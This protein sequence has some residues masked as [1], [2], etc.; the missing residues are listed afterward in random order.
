M[1]FRL[2]T[3]GAALLAVSSPLAH[4]Q[5]RG[6]AT[7]GLTLTTTSF[8]DGGEIP[9]RFTQGVEKPVSPTLAWTNVPA[10]TATLRAA[11]GLA[12]SRVHP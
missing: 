5:A 6:P 11:L 12:P 4:G 9:A 7:P 2:L 8:A 10:N 3:I 1:N